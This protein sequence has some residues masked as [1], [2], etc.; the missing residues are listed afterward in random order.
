LG[1]TVYRSECNKEETKGGM[2]SRAEN[3]SA[4]CFLILVHVPNSSRR[5]LALCVQ[6]WKPQTV[7]ADEGSSI[8]H[9]TPPQWTDTKQ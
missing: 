4:S 6:T 5:F 9:A 2:Q 1:H 8:W 3:I 7:E